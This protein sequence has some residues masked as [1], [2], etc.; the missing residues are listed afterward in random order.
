LDWHTLTSEEQVREI[1]ENISHSTT[2]VIFKHSTT[3]SLSAIA[4]H[5]MKDLTAAGPKGLHFYYLDLL[6]YRSVSNFIAETYD[7]VHKSPQ[8]LVIK[9]G[10]SIYDES[11]LSIN[12]D[13]VL[14]QIEPVN[15]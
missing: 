13:S 4:K 6:S 5:R 14:S 1:T 15:G 11:H 10:K 9:D 3:C 12:I 7:V 2:C 8:I